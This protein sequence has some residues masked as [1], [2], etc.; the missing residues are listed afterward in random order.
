MNS[1]KCFQKPAIRIVVV[2]SDPL[3]L[4][5]F[6][7]FLEFE[8]DFEF[9]YAS[10]SDCD[11]HDHIN[12]ILLCHQSDQHSF[13]DVVKLRAFYPNAQIIAIG[14]GMHDETIL[15]A[16]ALGAKGYLENGASAEEFI[17]AIRAVAGGSVWVSRHLLSA[18]VER[19]SSVVGNPLPGGRVASTPR[20]QEVLDLLVTGR[21]N[22]EIG[23]P[24]GI[25]ARTVKSHVSKLMRKADVRSR[26]ALSTYAISHSLVF[27]GS[28]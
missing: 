26:V 24:L 6:R 17:S 10:I 3:W 14:S 22:K 23:V 15:A 12:I 28:H 7:A 25:K 1:G 4:V 27:L 21:S 19:A 11:S 9:I 16:L 18:F 13:S 20:E 8:P 2:D 5:G